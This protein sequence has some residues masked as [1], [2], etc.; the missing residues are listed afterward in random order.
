VLTHAS[1]ATLGILVGA[2]L[3]WTLTGAGERG[4]GVGR[5]VLDTPN[6]TISLTGSLSQAISP[7]VFAPLDLTISNS[8]TV[9]IVVSEL[10]VTVSAVN[11]PNATA[12]Q[13]CT[14]ADFDVRKI[15]QRY[16]VFVG[17]KSASTLS[18]LGLPPTAWPQVGMPLNESRNQDGC[19][20]V[21]L[22][23]SYTAV[24]RARS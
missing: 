2:A 18:Q 23:L 8:K 3:V 15:S 7:G 6:D 1:S 4:E 11:A 17:A 5:G 13:P 9:P 20:G 21:S 14:A 19:K 16:T 24:G 10:T 22:T 12:S